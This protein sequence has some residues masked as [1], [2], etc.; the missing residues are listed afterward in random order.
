KCW[1]SI[2]T[3][4]IEIIGLEPG[5]GIDSIV[6]RSN[7]LSPNRLNSLKFPLATWPPLDMQNVTF[8][9][10]I[11]ADV[12]FTNDNPTN[13]KILTWLNEP[14]FQHCRFEPPVL[15]IPD[16]ICLGELFEIRMEL[17]GFPTYYSWFLDD[18]V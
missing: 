16:T 13:R 18:D 15:E 7:V 10:R 9:G 4:F 5:M 14:I 6:W 17:E 8:N 11:T 1:G 2:D 3:L 12:Y